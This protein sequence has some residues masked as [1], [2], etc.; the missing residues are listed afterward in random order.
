MLT[1]EQIEIILDNDNIGKFSLTR[2]YLCSMSVFEGL[3]DYYESNL[4]KT[5]IG[6]V[7]LSPEDYKE[8]KE[9]IIALIA[10]DPSKFLFDNNSKTITNKEGD[11]TVF[12]NFS[13]FDDDERKRV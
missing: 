2:G 7:L 13:S 6:E 11:I 12:H 3:E 5:T 8:V 1:K 10:K 9:K 4:E